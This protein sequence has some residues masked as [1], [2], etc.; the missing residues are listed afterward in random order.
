MSE[1]TAPHHWLG[2][3]TC[4]T[5]EGDIDFPDEYAELGVCRHCGIAF[6]VDADQHRRGCGAVGRDERRRG[7]GAVGRAGSSRAS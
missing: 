7:R 4:E 1:L 2:A 3:M 6:L 5:C